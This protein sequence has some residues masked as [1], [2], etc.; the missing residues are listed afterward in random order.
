MSAVASQRENAAD[1]ERSRSRSPVRER[2]SEPAA[3][4]RKAGGMRGHSTVNV[5]NW[6]IP[7]ASGRNKFG[8]LMWNL[9][10]PDYNGTSF[11][12]HEMPGPD[13]EGDA[14][15]T[16]IWSLQGERD[17]APVNNCKLT[18]DI[19]DRQEASIMKMDERILTQ[20]EKQSM[21][22][23]SQKNPVRLDLLRAQHYKSPLVP[24]TETQ[25]P[26][27]NLRFV[28][29]GHPQRLTTMHYF[30]LAADG[31]THEKVPIIARGWDQ[32]EPLI[33]GSFLKGAKCRLLG[34]RIWSLSVMKK[35]IYPGFD[36]ETIYVKEGVQ[37]ST[38]FN[39]L[40]AEEE[41]RM[42]EMA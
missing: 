31:K 36:I 11:S 42:L 15:S 27:A 3:P 30:K 28:I 6:V 7:P 33:Q 37:D 40:S 19:N 25:G 14:W 8:S 16:I 35:E 32:I 24:Q 20:I 1:R 22:M 23:L 13:C 17:G 18:V 39:G 21:E 5:D 12:L 34:V 26:R 4:V 41:E 38:S 2:P 9:K 29:R 10:S